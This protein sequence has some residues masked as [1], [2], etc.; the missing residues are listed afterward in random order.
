MQSHIDNPVLVGR[1]VREA[2]RSAHLTLREL[3]F[4]GCS[5]PYL[6]HI[7]RGRRTPS[8]QVLVE[9]GRRLGTDPQFLA[10]GE[11][12]QGHALQLSSAV[13]IYERALTI[14]RT[15][16]ERLWV[17]TG[18]AQAAVLKGDLVT[19]RAALESATATLEHLA[20]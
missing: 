15:D 6:S 4:P 5:A 19:A 16:D 20:A 12:T 3:A 14:A 2:R 8:L 11:V 7:E 17:L 10:R 13:D 18:L 1:R 9:L